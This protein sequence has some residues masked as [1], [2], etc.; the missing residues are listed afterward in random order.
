MTPSYHTVRNERDETA[1]SA[2]HPRV[3]HVITG[4]G[5]GGA[6]KVVCQL[7]SYAGGQ[8]GIIWLK[9]PLVKWQD[10]LE[11]AGVHLMPLHI[12]GLRSLP[13]AIKLLRQQIAQFQPDVVHG[14]L[15]HAQLLTRWALRGMRSMPLITTQHNVYPAAR[16]I[17]RWLIKLNAVTCRQDR[18]IVAVSEAVCRKLKVE[19]FRAKEIRVIYNGIEPPVGPP[20]Y[21]IQ[22]PPVITLV[23]RLN[24]EK[25]VDI[26]L[27]ALRMLPECRGWLVGIGSE[28][29]SKRVEELLQRDNLL[30]RVRWDRTGMEGFRAM[31][32][33]SVVV[34]PSR[35]EGLGIVALEAMSLG[36]P[37]VASR[38]DGLSEVVQEG[39]TGLLITPESPEALAEAVRSVLSDPFRAVEMGRAGRRRVEERFSLSKM[40]ASYRQLYHEILQDYP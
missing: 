11:R 12:Q 30:S 34:V 2:V 24:R 20:P 17:P 4:M 14:H 15:I 22:T 35:S 33:A 32:E 23:G 9:G 16:H 8:G 37:V 19:G 27:D 25:G 3:L 10:E 39:V 31:T 13:R 38:V 26:F 7:A 36:R 21:A 1:N 28:R 18:A 29:E 5:L 40:R 6:E